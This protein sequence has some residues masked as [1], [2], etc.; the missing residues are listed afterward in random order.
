MNEAVS[1]VKQDPLIEE[2]VR[3][4][5]ECLRRTIKQ[6]RMEKHGVRAQAQA[7][8]VSATSLRKWL[9]DD[10][11]PTD[12]ILRRLKSILTLT[13]EDVRTIRRGINR[14]RSLA[15]QGTRTSVAEADEASRGGGRRHRTSPRPP[16]GAQKPAGVAGTH[17]Q[18]LQEIRAILAR[19]GLTDPARRRA[20]DHWT[21]GGL[22]FVLTPQNFTSLDGKYWTPAT[23]KETVRL[24]RELRKRLITLAQLGPD[25]ARTETLRD[26][27][28]ELREL[29]IAYTAANA[30]VPIQCV[31]TIE[32]QMLRERLQ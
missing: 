15:S 9:N 19:I 10:R 8:R 2:A 16:E 13:R 7:L 12:R 22:P 24:I 17:A 6:R 23:T 1:V 27:A 26:L 3:R 25:P 30:V 32:E 4:L 28:A 29:F 31:K 14:R 21:V 18:A 11:L 5:R 20:E